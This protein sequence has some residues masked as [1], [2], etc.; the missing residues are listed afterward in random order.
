MNFAYR[1]KT[2]EERPGNAHGSSRKVLAAQA[3]RTGERQYTRGEQI[4]VKG[5]LCLLVIAPPL[6]GQNSAPANVDRASYFRMPL[7]HAL[8]EAWLSNSMPVDE[9]SAGYSPMKRF[10]PTFL[11]LPVRVGCVLPQDELLD[12]GVGESAAG[13]DESAG[14]DQSWS[15][16]ARRIV[17]ICERGR[18]QVAANS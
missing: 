1:F 10:P 2:P 14:K 13:V 17:K 4:I 18:D 11:N 9:P 3:G 16:I 15:A 5:L 6:L 8:G 7:Q 12:Q